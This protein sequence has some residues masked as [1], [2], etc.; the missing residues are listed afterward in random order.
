MADRLYTTRETDEI[1]SALRLETRLEKYI[2]A[3]IAFSLSLTEDGQNVSIGTDAMDAL[4]HGSYNVA[5]GGQSQTA[6][7]TK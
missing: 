7:T 6:A 2:L 4:T 1:L 5:V 3:R